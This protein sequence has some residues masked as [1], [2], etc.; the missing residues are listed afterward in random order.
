RRIRRLS[1]RGYRTRHVQD[2]AE[3]AR[4]DREM[5]VPFSNARHADNATHILPEQVQKIAHAGRL[6]LLLAGDEPVGAHLGYY[7]FQGGKRYWTTL[8]FGYPASVFNDPKRLAEANTMNLHLAMK[9]AIDAG[10][11]YYDIGVSLARPDGGLL[12]FKRRRHG[13]LDP[14]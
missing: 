8:R 12:Q 13:F 14:H 11:D 3:I 1:E 6:D 5:L 9:Y 2:D 7:H 10:S 4:L